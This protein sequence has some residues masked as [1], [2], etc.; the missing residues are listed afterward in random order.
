MKE[1]D[2]VLV[3]VFL[4]YLVK[5][6]IKY[7]HSKDMYSPVCLDL[8]LQL[9]KH[10]LRKTLLSLKFFAF[11]RIYNLRYGKTICIFP[12]TSSKLI[13]C[14]Y[15]HSA[16]P[17]HTHMMTSLTSALVVLTE[18]SENCTQDQNDVALS[19]TTSSFPWFKQGCFCL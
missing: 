15:S 10:F 4:F 12:T 8:K 3:H 9:L 7:T 1:N 17:L 11:V 18:M 13:H 16:A 2:Y 14:V 6:H 19:N 5:K